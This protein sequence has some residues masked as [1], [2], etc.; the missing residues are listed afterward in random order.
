MLGLRSQV[1][2][3]RS[4][5]LDFRVDLQSEIFHL[6]SSIWDSVAHLDSDHTTVMIQGE[7]GTGKSVLAKAMHYASPRA[8]MQLLELN[9][10]ALPDTLLESELFGFEPGAS[11]DARRNEGLLERAHGGTLFL[12][13]IATMSPSVQAKLLRVLEDGTF[14]RL[15]GTR[16]ITI[17][18][19]IIAATNSNLR[20]AV[21]RGQFREDL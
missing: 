17:N 10:A 8:D 9:C 13:E 6:K 21:A 16:P 15:G 18:V 7:S 12:D 20:E 1:S 5:A 3:V 4:L 11:T 2:G 14:T 19:R